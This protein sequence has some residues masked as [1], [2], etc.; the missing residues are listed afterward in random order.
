MWH[1]F[2]YDTISC[3]RLWRFPSHS[4]KHFAV[5]KTSPLEVN[6][7]GSSEFRRRIDRMTEIVVRSRRDKG[8]REITAYLEVVE[9]P[10]GS[11]ELLGL[12]EKLLEK[13]DH[14]R[15]GDLIS[16]HD[17]TSKNEMKRLH[18]LGSRC[19]DGNKVDKCDGSYSEST[20][21][22]FV[23]VNVG[24]S[25]DC[26][27]D[28]KKCVD[29][30]S[31]VSSPPGAVDLNV[32]MMM[33]H[34][35]QQ[36]K[37]NRRSGQS[38]Q[39]FK[40]IEE[41]NVSR[42]LLDVF[43]L[44]VMTA[45][46]VDAIDGTPSSASLLN[47]LHLHFDDD[48]FSPIPRAVNSSKLY[49]PTASSPHVDAV[50]NNVT[51]KSSGVSNFITLE[52]FITAMANSP[53]WKNVHA[54]LTEF[55]QHSSWQKSYS[56]LDVITCLNILHGTVLDKSLHLLTLQAIRTLNGEGSASSTSIYREGLDF[57]RYL[58]ANTV[59]WRDESAGN[60]RRT[61]STRTNR[62]MNTGD[63]SEY[64][65]RT[66]DACDEI[67]SFMGCRTGLIG[68]MDEVGGNK[69][70][71]GDGSGEGKDRDIKQDTK[72][73]F[74]TD[75]RISAAVELT[76]NFLSSAEHTHTSTGSSARGVSPTTEFLYCSFFESIQG[77]IKGTNWKDG[78]SSTCDSS[79]GMLGI[80]EKEEADE[81]E[82]NV[83]KRIRILI[84][85][86][87]DI[88]FS[89]A[90]IKLQQERLS[91][92]NRRVDRIVRTDED[93]DENLV[94][95]EEG[96]RSSDGQRGVGRG[97]GREIL[98]SD[99]TPEGTARHQIVDLPHSVPLHIIATSFETQSSLFRKYAGAEENVRFITG[100]TSRASRDRKGIS[101]STDSNSS[102]INSN[103]SSNSSNSNSNSKVVHIA[104][105]RG[106][107]GSP[108]KAVEEESGHRVMYQ[109]DATNVL[110]SDFQGEAFDT[111]IFNFPFADALNTGSDASN[112]RR[113]RSG[114]PK[115]STVSSEQKSMD[116]D[117]GSAVKGP[118]LSAEEFS[119]STESS[120]SSNGDFDNGSDSDSDS[121]GSQTDPIESP[122]KEKIKR[123][124]SGR[125]SDFDTHWVARGRH[126]HLLDGVFRSAK[127]VLKKVPKTALHSRNQNHSSSDSEL[128]SQEEGRVG[129]GIRNGRVR[130]PRVMVTLLLSQALEWE[131]ERLAT[132]HGFCLT[133]IIPF[134]DLIF[135]ATGY[136]RKRTYADDIFPS[137]S[138]SALSGRSSSTSPSPAPCP[139]D[140]SK[141]DSHLTH[142]GDGSQTAHSNARFLYSLQRKQ[143]QK[144][145]V[146]AWTFVFTHSS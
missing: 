9:G 55:K 118:Q 89:A 69:D 43:F 130:G 47:S 134:E 12:M 73:S 127:N 88:S 97:R 53:S 83:P 123:S 36:M 15:F 81:E 19:S 129:V 86:D 18:S 77:S 67:L 14:S 29:F 84:L 131:V 39:L 132:V 76:Q 68:D 92:H 52:I 120:S 56:N 100:S 107:S 20:N 93:E 5:R 114:F 34:S 6:S 110:M 125:S 24:L 33:V 108:S 49:N 141:L 46:N 7:D 64:V 94:A 79:V 30:T 140:A 112:A 3:N 85:G 38:A 109:V 90:L 42:R 106:D 105:E 145:T 11:T 113:G 104:E 137:S 116:G 87:G 21:T 136:S 133:E 128:E 61:R 80:E 75:P 51:M 95:I 124:K 99:V 10:V 57:I 37:P 54:V 142:I 98:C 111:V 58:L 117:S 146:V 139:S 25:A 72:G 8:T 22:A 65:Y 138:S 50:A 115:V 28:G 45:Q 101:L 102:S 13:R 96:K 78:S 48:S 16:L 66:S 17:V 26:S 143:W 126:M 4:R 135:A 40:K 122:S 103:I 63:K 31:D 1:L 74:F 71:D 2:F 44:S 82:G 60:E 23:G 41:M 59:V 27:S 32:L 91:L 35:V 70:E 62:I 144:N 119:D 121:A